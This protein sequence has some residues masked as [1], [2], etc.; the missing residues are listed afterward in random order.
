VTST[1]SPAPPD[2]APVARSSLGP[3]VKENGYYVGHNIQRAVDEIA[4]ANGVSNKVTPLVHPH[5]HSDHA[6]AAG[7]FGDRAGR[8]RDVSRRLGDLS[9]N[10]N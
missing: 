1:T 6:G 4:A 10:V 9:R 8:L 3:A 5:H 2:Y 7:L